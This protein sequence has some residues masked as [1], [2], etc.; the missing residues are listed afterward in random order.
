MTD[1]NERTRAIINDAR[2]S[3]PVRDAALE[4]ERQYR[5]AEWTPEQEAELIERQHGTER[6]RIDRLVSEHNERQRHR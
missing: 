5:P 4:A 1:N 2:R 6:E 3:D